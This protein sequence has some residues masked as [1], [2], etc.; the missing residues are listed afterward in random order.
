MIT[1]RWWNDT[2]RVEQKYWEKIYVLRPH[3]INFSIIYVP[4]S[5]R[6]KKVIINSQLFL[7]KNHG[8]RTYEEFDRRQKYSK[9]TGRH[10]VL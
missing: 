8:K 4:R 2:D 3:Y 6:P 10:T 1:Q 5:V 7:V 9:K